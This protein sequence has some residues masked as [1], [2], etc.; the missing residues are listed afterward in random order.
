M[1]PEGETIGVSRRTGGDVIPDDVPLVGRG[2]A[3]L[4]PAARASPSYCWREVLVRRV[5]RENT[6]RR[7]SHWK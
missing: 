3:G 2:W 4:S 7:A 5:R 6:P 1:L